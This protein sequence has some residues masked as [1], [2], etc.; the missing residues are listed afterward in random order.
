[1]VSGLDNLADHKCPQGVP[2]MSDIPVPRQI[3]RRGGGPGVI[4]RHAGSRSNSITTS[5]AT[6]ASANG[7]FD[8]PALRLEGISKEFSKIAPKRKTDDLSPAVPQDLTRPVVKRMKTNF[9]PS[10]SS[11]WN[12][13]VSSE[14]GNGINGE[15]QR[16]KVDKKNKHKS[17]SSKPGH[18]SHLL[19]ESV[20]NNHETQHLVKDPNL[21]PNLARV[22][23]EPHTL[24]VTQE[25]QAMQKGKVQF[26][27]NKN[28]VRSEKVKPRL[29][30]STKGSLREDDYDYGEEVSL[31]SSSVHRKTS[32]SEL[33]DSSEGVSNSCISQRKKAQQAILT[34]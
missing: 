16:I 5:Q 15:K 17:S 29:R 30:R 7:H 23:S 34:Q 26:S 12:G 19:L 32:K 3:S 8:H 28:G 27:K 14:V 10:N 22:S 1:M 33:S 25:D 11:P 2:G 9:P 18:L 4:F 13:D 20:N 24:A 21:A 31:L 6:L